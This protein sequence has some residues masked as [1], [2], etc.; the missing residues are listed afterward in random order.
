MEQR[1]KAAS[2]VVDNTAEVVVVVGGGGVVVVRVSS[3]FF[4]FR[5]SDYRSARFTGDFFFFCLILPVL[6][7]VPT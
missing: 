6:S 1:K 7:L 4:P 2:E 3:I 5:F